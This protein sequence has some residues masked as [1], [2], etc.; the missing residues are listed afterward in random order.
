MITTKKAGI[1]ID[2]SNA[3]IMEVSGGAI[4]TKII[5]SKFTLKEKEIS[6]DKG[7]SQMH[8]KEQH[9][10]S[11]Y[12]KKLGEAIR[13][14][15]DVILFGPTDAK[16]ELYNKLKDDHLFAKIKIAVKHTDKM[17]EHQQH[18]FVKEYFSR[19]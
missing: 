18:T 4:E 19:S 6:L 15:D 12:Y 2:H 7:E 8:S 17:S 3:H 14:Y 13:N 1:W 16:A 10:Q 5:S 9:W 11:E